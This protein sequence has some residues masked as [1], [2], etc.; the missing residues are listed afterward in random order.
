MKKTYFKTI[1]RCKLSIERFRWISLLMLL[2]FTLPGFSQSYCAPNYGSG[3]DYGDYIGVFSIP[4][5]G[6][7]H[8]SG[9]CNNSY[10]DYTGNDEFQISLIAG[11]GTSYSITHAETNQRVKIWIDFDNSMSFEDGEQVSHAIGTTATTTTNIITVPVTVEP[12]IYRMRVSTRYNTDPTPCNT[13]FSIYGESN[14]YMVEILPPAPC[15]PPTGLA[16]GNI[17]SDSAV[18]N[19]D[20]SDNNS[21]YIEWGSTL[22]NPGEGDN[23][24]TATGTSFTFND[25]EA[26]TTYYFYINTICSGIGE[27]SVQGP[28][29]FTTT[30]DSVEEFSEGFE[31]EDLPDCWSFYAD[32]V[33]DLYLSFST[34]PAN[35]NS[36]NQSLDVY[37]YSIGNAIYMVS[38]LLPNINADTHRLTFYAKGSSNTK[39]DVGIS[40]TNASVANVNYFYATEEDN[41]LTS[42]MKKYSINFDQ[43]YT[44]NFIVIKITFDA[45]WTSSII[46][47]IVWE[48]IPT[49]ADVSNVILSGVTSNSASIS[50]T[51]LGT[52]TAWQYAIGSSTDLNPDDL[53]AIDVPG[54]LPSATISDL[55]ANTSYKIWIRSNCSENYGSWHSA[56]TILT[57]CEAEL[58]ETITQEFTTAIPACWS[59]AT[60]VLSENIVLT[61]STTAWGNK[62]FA[63]GTTTPTN[64][65]AY[66]NLYNTKNSWLI[67]QPIDLGE[68][69]GEY[70]LSYKY[71]LTAYNQ[72]TA[73]PTLETHKVTVM[74]STDG[75]A[76]WSITDD[77]LKTYENAGQYSNTG[78]VEKINLTNYSGVVKI[79]FVA[80]TSGTTHDFDFFIDDFKIESIP[81]CQDVSSITT[82]NKTYSSADISFSI[83]GTETA[84]QYYMGESSET[85]PSESGAIDITSPQFSLSNL[86][87]ATTYKVWIRANCGQGNYGNWSEPYLITTYNTCGNLF[88]D[89]IIEPNNYLNNMHLTTTYYPQNAGEIITVTF[90]EFATEETYDGLMIYDGPDTNSPIISSGYVAAYTNARCPSGAWNGDSTYSPV[91]VEIQ[92]SHITGAL[93]FVFRSDGSTTFSGWSATVDC[94]ET[95]DCIRPTLLEVTALTATTANLSWTPQGDETAWAIAY[96]SDATII[97][98]EDLTPENATSSTTTIEDLTPATSYKVWIKAT[99]ENSDSAWL[100]PITFTTECATETAPTVAQNFSTYIPNCWTEANGILGATSEVIEGSNAWTSHPFANTGSNSSAYINLFGANNAWLI[101]NSIDLGAIPGQ[102]RLSYKYAVSDYN[103]NGPSGYG[104][105]K[106]NVIISTDGGNTWSNVNNLKEYSGD[107]I[108]ENSHTG[109]VE[110]IYLTEYSGVIK[111]AFVATTSTYNPDLRFFIDDFLIEALPN[112]SDISNISASNIT[113]N[114]ATITFNTEGNETAWQYV[115]GSDSDVNPNELSPEELS[116]STF[117]ISNLD[118]NTNYKVWVRTIC[119][120]GFGAW[121]QAYS[122]YT[123][124]CV[125]STTNTSDYISALTINTDYSNINYTASGQPT[126]SYE[127]NSEEIIEAEQGGTINFIHSFEGGA[128]YL[129]IWVDWNN[130]MMFNNT[131]SPENIEKVFYLGTSSTTINN[132]FVVPADMPVGEYRIRFRSAYGSTANPAPCGNTNY[133]STV[134]YTLNVTQGMSTNDFSNK[135]L[136]TFPNPVKDFLNI[137]NNKNISSVIIYNLLGQEVQNL[138]VNDNNLQV[139]MSTLTSGTYLVKIQSEDTI[140]TVKVIKQ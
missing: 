14:D 89:S 54:T 115:L 82:S 101:S 34:T 135:D 5:I 112:C 84:W 10:N 63:N 129:N 76:T 57:N 75:G 61:P 110:K 136:K 117:T 39:V 60:G 137:S 29:S 86:E 95:P 134:D 123:G 71:A 81:S 80:S 65:A 27:S 6:F 51:P 1:S 125:V 68:T 114:S 12:G 64:T 99:C 24:E 13:G 62:A 43:G 32:S 55:E 33:S 139:N 126:G 69:S 46:D 16:Y 35:I 9:G 30:C 118:E 47:D 20:N 138:N 73:V 113:S 40:N 121:S 130:D 70:R 19:F 53:V 37:S 120:E 44:G 94:I 21:F 90:S 2:S 48:S 8:D 56:L 11:E 26:N 7:S 88:T 72:T 59:M 93:T 122:F 66:I 77:I 18:L 131:S 92:S 15:T 102:Y 49:C 79:A 107:A 127:D 52:E 78:I 58:P 124:Y 36:G 25:L 38:P 111:I 132:N 97:S 128:N 104:T 83:N 100:G 87:S 67:S 91:G 106:V 50:W 119:T 133:G 105:H 17:I 42:S 22:F 116:N 41:G 103:S 4:S 109:I 3:C 31:G 45:A 96:T 140:R 74:I 23:S 98:A 28:F 85:E 108:I